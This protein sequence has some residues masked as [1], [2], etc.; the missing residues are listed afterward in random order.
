MNARPNHPQLTPTQTDAKEALTKGLE[1]A[2]ILAIGGATGRGKSTVLADLQ[3]ELGGT[4]LS[5]SDLLE[6]T[7]RRHPLAPGRKRIRP[8]QAGI[9]AR[10][11]RDCRRLRN[12][13]DD[14]LLPRCLSANEVA[15]WGLPRS[16]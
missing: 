12:P 3:S 6:E 8:H 14:G 15:G 16:L 4:M 11:F 2:S 10:P 5:I 9:E 13:S 1:V 7:A